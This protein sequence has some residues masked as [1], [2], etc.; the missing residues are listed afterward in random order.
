MA[1]CFL[2]FCSAAHSGKYSRQF[3]QIR[4]VARYLGNE[5]LATPGAFEKTRVDL[6]RDH[7]EV[8]SRETFNTWRGT[9]RYAYL[10]LHASSEEERKRIKDKA[11]EAYGFG[12]LCLLEDNLSEW[13]QLNDLI[14]ERGALPAESSPPET[15]PIALPADF[16]WKNDA[17]TIVYTSGFHRS[18]MDLESFEKRQIASSLV[19]LAQHGQSH[20]SLQTKVYRDDNKNLNSRFP[21]LAN[22][23]RF[24]RGTK[25]LRFGWIKQGSVLTVHYL[26]RKSDTRL[27]QSEK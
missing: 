26:W 19:L 5:Y 11:G 9:L 1:I 2:D 14:S 20:P 24:C 16:S 7:N 15:P 3:T 27:R 23:G 6:R 22:G 4:L 10:Y 13:S 25:S 21:A 12:I 8:I 18:F 17:G